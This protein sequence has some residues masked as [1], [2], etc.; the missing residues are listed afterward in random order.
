[1]GKITWVHNPK[2]LSFKST[3]TPEGGG[4]IAMFTIV[5]GA[6]VSLFSFYS[7]SPVVFVCFYAHPYLSVGCLN[8]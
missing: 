7:Y 1:V 8:G 5:G 3:R 6:R 2:F 4:R